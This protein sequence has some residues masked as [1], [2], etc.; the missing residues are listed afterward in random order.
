MWFPGYLCYLYSAEKPYALELNINYH[1]LNN[2][3]KITDPLLTLSRKK[4]MIQKIFV[5][6][7]SYSC[8]AV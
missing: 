8:V 4:T 7:L 1:C 3:G 5:A 6:N 2:Y